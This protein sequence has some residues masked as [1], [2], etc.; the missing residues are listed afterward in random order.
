[1]NI[2][3]MVLAIAISCALIFTIS[4]L[5]YENIVINKLKWLR[6]E[7]LDDIF[8]FTHKGVYLGRIIRT[9]DPLK[10]GF[11]IMSPDKKY[12]DKLSWL[13]AVDRIQYPILFHTRFII[14]HFFM[15]PEHIPDI[16]TL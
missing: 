3:Y 15:K 14:N 10:H 9:T 5:C 1:M 12:T 13:Q 2:G 4:C 6:N 8:V 7:K 11:A 16:A